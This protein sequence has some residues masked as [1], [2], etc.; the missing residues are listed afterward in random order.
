MR[1]L[2]IASTLVFW[3]AVAGFWAAGLWLPEPSAQSAPMT[4]ADSHYTLAELAVHNQVD[5]CWM[6]IDGSVYDFTRYLS[7]HPAPPALM[8]AWC[9]K[10]ATQA[11]NTKTKGR[12]HS[13]YAAQLLPQ[14]C[15][16]ELGEE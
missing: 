9:G 15:I 4:A 3:F 7:Q 16:G 2:F 1:K 12:P 6:A 11:F 5:D 13:P 10:E 8:L 14:Y